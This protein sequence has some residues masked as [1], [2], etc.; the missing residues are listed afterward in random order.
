MREDILQRFA[1]HPVAANLLMLILIIV[2]TLGL[3]RLN[4]QFFPT[5]S[6][7]FITVNVNWTGASAEDVARGITAPLERELQN[8]DGVKTMTSSSATGHVAIVIELNADTDMQTALDQVKALVEQTSGLPSTADKPV[9][10][11]VLR[12]ENVGRLLLVGGDDLETLRPLAQRFRQQLLDRGIAKVEITG[13]PKQEI[14]IEVPA[15]TLAQMSASSSSLGPQTAQASRD[16]PMGVAGRKEAA[17]QLRFVEQRRSVSGFSQL[18]VSTDKGGRQTRL[19]DIASIHKQDRDGEVQVWYKGRPAVDLKL[20]RS[21]TGDSLKSARI[22][23][24]WLQETRPLLPEGVAI[25]AYNQRWTLIED[26]INLLIKNGLTGL[27][28]VVIM[29]FLFLN[30]RVAWWVSLGI[31]VSFMATLWILFMVGG[32]INMISLFALIMALG[33]IVD[34]AIVVGEDALSHYQMGEPPLAAVVGGARRMLA[35]VL[36]SSLTT[37]GAFL[38]LML[39]GGI[40]GNIL[41]DIPLIIVCVILASLLESFFVLPGHLH[42]SLA[43]VGHYH[44]SGIRQRLDD[45]FNRFRDGPF[46]RLVTRSLDLRWTTLAAGLALLVLSVGLIVGG[47]LKFHFFPT[48]EGTTVYGSV[49]FVSG[50]PREKVHNYL[51]NMEKSLYAAEQSFSDQLVSTAIVLDGQMVRDGNNRSRGDV[52][53][54]VQVEMTQPDSRRVRNKSFLKAWRKRLQLVPG[55]ESLSVFERRGGPPGRDIDIRLIGGDTPTLKKAATELEALLKTLKGVTSVADDLPYGREQLVLSLTPQ[56]LALGLTVDQ[57]SRQLRSAFDGYLVQVFPQG[58]DELEVRVRLPSEQRDYLNQI[59][60]LTL[61]TSSGQNVLLSNVLSIT[62]RRGF[63]LVRRA[64]NRPAVTVQGDVDSSVNNSNQI[65]SKLEAGPLR[66]L[67]ARYGV[68]YSLQGRAADQ[69]Q[70]LGDLRLGMLYA[71]AM[72]YLVLAWVFSS[73]AWPLVV[74]MIIPFGLVGALWGHYL[75]HLDLTILSLFGFFGLSGIVVNDSI[76]LVVFYRE[77]RHQGQL[78][79]EALIEAVRLRL[80][81]V[82]LTSLTTI[83]GLTPLLF[84]QSRQAQFLI[85]MATSIAFGLMFSTIMVLFLVPALLYVY[86]RA[87]ER[88]GFHRKIPVVS[89]SY[90]TKL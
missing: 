26:R 90:Q 84:E 8:V 7:D 77:R 68:D 9:V 21:E 4:I 54:T 64:D 55:I 23:N 50:T 2:G 46:C 5:F 33:I 52:F 18:V 57:V 82:L 14:T 71:L 51:L 58:D 43:K 17:R 29:L 85:P 32:S 88:F 16:V 25:I 41:F 74:M 28:L 61:T 24:Q 36:S 1:R 67:V 39:V 86:E 87:A 19:G 72:M 30:A 59:E 6:L 11:R 80:R 42:H 49:A 38:P 27:A 78:V 48:P 10:S 66:N 76:I 53:G 40:I 79:R 70:T 3:N 75:M 13:L 60:Q 20:Q 15:R 45:L 81:P 22:Q 69:K 12:H 31:P 37:V 35:P 73:Y 56:G 83:G 47:R 34:D 44:P 65:L 62:T 89:G 63:D